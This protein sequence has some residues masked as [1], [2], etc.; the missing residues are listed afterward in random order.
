QNEDQL[1]VNGLFGYSS[2]EAVQYFESIQLK[3]PVHKQYQIP[4]VCYQYFKYVIAINHFKNMMVIFENL[5]ENEESQI[6]RIERLLFTMNIT[7]GRFT[8]GNNET[9]N[10]TD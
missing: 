10:L 5:V 2:Y 8:A 1:P 4:E 3:A 6:D 7:S 9:S